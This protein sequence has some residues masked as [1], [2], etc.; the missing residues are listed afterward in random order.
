MA[1]INMQ[2]SVENEALGKKLFSMIVV[3]DTHLSEQD[4]VSNSPFPVN[5]LANGRM[6][7]VVQDINALAPDF[8]INLGD[9]IHPVPGVPHAYKDAVERFLEQTANLNCPQHLVPGNHDVGI[10][11]STGPRPG[12]CVMIIWP[13]GKSILVRII[14]PL[15]IK[16][17]IF[18]W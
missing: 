7:H 12:W 5:R 13:C 16:A 3:A 15:N 10:N 18:W 1:E 17:Y 8:V 14:M 11:P 6:K 2:N 4:M 9:L